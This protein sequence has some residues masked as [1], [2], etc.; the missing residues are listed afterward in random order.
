MLTAYV[1]R[2][3][4]KGF[5]TGDGDVPTAIAMLMSTM[6]G[7]AISRSVMP[8]VFP[9]PESEAP[10]RYVRVFMRALGV[11]PARVRAPMLHSATGD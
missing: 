7:D 10:A 5:A 11:S 8:G 9:Q 4:A 3:Q 6:F 2:L 1:E